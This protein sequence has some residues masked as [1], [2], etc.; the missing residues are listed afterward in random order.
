MSF[1][2]RKLSLGHVHTLLRSLDIIVFLGVGFLGHLILLLG[3]CDLSIQLG[4]A[5]T[6]RGCQGFCFCK[7][8]RR[9]ISLFLCSSRLCCLC[10]CSALCC[11][12]ICCGILCSCLAGRN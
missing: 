7:A 8:C 10:I 6:T 9:C 5:C 12:D 4:D 1:P 2:L 3:C 11:R